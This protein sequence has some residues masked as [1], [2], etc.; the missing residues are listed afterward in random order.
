[1]AQARSTSALLCIAGGLALAGC[2]QKYARVQIYSEPLGA[3]VRTPKGDVLGLTPLTLEGDTLKQA[4]PDGRS[5]SV[6][7]DAP[8][9][10]ASNQSMEIRGKDKY[11]IR[12]RRVDE[13]AFR[14]GVLFQY[15]Q[16]MNRM[17]RELLSIQGM[18][19]VKKT[20]DASRALQEFHGKYPNV[21]AGYVMSA[22]V[23]IVKGELETAHGYLLKARS[24]D[25]TDTVVLQMIASLNTFGTRK[26][27]NLTDEDQ[28]ALSEA[29]ETPDPGEPEVDAEN[30]GP[31]ANEAGE[32]AEAAPADAGEG[33][34]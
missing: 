15:G 2:S 14:E 32:D 18:I 21:A 4:A 29:A 7:L 6:V 27:R 5:L 16:Q 30:R 10:V 17:V 9:Y 20:D 8:G 34:L 1:M 22:N 19:L 24:I 28:K 11:E 23:A 25:P 13:D 3:E 33:G 12:L 31:A 26:Y